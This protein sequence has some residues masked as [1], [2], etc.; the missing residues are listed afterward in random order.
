MESRK[1]N[2]LSGFF[3]EHNK[4]QP[5]TTKG[6][7]L[8]AVKKEGEFSAQ[9]FT[10]FESCGILCLFSIQHAAGPFISIAAAQRKDDNSEYM[11]SG[12]RA[13]YGKGRKT[14]EILSE[15]CGTGH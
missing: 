8:F 7:F 14:R 2:P 15:G 4:R 11:Y 12:D 5:F 3:A 6:C 10:F 13:L 1:A 9:P